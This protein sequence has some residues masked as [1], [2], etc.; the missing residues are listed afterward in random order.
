MSELKSAED[1]VIGT[2]FFGMA[3]GPSGSGKK[4]AM[5]TFPKPMRYFDFD[6]RIDGLLGSPWV[7][8]KGI[9]YS[10]HSIKNPS[11]AAAEIVQFLNKELQIILN[12]CIS[13]QNKYQT[14]IW[15]SLT[16]QTESFILESLPFT[17]QSKATGSDKNKGRNIGPIQMAGM[18]DYG[19]ESSGTMQ[20]MSYLK[21]LN[22]FIPN[23]IVMA[24]VIPRFGKQD[25]NDPYS[26]SVE[27]GEKLSIRD[28]I[29]A[30]TIKNF[31]HV[32]KFSKDLFGGNMKYMVEFHGDL[33]RTS[34]PN[35]P[36]GKLD[37][38][39][40]NFYDTLQKVIKGIK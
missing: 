19:F 20:C 25:P 21:A 29:G 11:A 13:G 8:R 2:K 32:F 18:E 6:G 12:N 14:L 24:H 28:K 30:N 17:H 37:I 35:L 4:S 31:N 38:T 34:Y 5:C 22:Q 10:Q 1:L 40:I 27:I 26:P 23:I 9:D 3:V 16:G 39:A 7:D 33:A 15:A 36:T